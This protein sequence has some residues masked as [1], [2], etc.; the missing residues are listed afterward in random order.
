VHRYMFLV[1]L[2]RHANAQI[3]HSRASYST[4]GLRLHL[5]YFLKICDLRFFMSGFAGNNIYLGQRSSVFTYVIHC[6]RQ[7]SLRSLHPHREQTLC[8]LTTMSH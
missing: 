3:M 6:V 7:Q 5:Y 1:E 8:Y 2:L 4:A